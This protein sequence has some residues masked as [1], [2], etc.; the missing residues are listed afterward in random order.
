M[1]NRAGQKNYR[2]HVTQ[3]KINRAKEKY[4]HDMMIINANEDKLTLDSLLKVKRANEN[5]KDISKE[6]DN[7]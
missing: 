6:G 4:N 2:N 5:T 7:N 1:A 3:L